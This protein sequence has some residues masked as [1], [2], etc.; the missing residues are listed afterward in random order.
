MSLA[1]IALTESR[2]HDDPMNY[3]DSVCGKPLDFIDRSI[4]RS[5]STS[6]YRNE[7]VYFP[8]TVYGDDIIIDARATPELMRNLTVLGFEPNHSK[9]FQGG[10]AVRES[11]GE[12]FLHGSNV[13]PLTVKVKWF[14]DTLT[15]AAYAS[16][17]GFANLSEKRGYLNLRSFVISYLKGVTR[18]KRQ[19]KV[20]FTTNEDSFGI[21]TPQRHLRDEKVRWSP[22]DPKGSYYQR[23]EIS[24]LVVSTQMAKTHEDYSDMYSYHLHQ[25][26]D[27]SLEDG[28]PVEAHSRMRADSLRIRPRWT[29]VG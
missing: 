4:L 17:V 1:S 6:G 28:E 25:Q 23:E 29:P 13:T 10:Q 21:F 15:G 27:V 12:Y 22:D 3:V 20:A 9:S 24:E 5:H 19:F 16:L 18:G 11:C 14:D 26:R 8:L 2:H 7:G